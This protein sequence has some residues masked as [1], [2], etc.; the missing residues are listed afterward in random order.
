MVLEIFFLYL[1][2]LRSFV[3]RVDY[4]ASFADPTSFL[5]VVQPSDQSRSKEY[6][7]QHEVAKGHH[8][9]HQIWQSKQQLNLFFHFLKKKNRGAVFIFQVF[10][11]M[12]QVLLFLPGPQHELMIWRKAPWAFAL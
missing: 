9:L 10:Q 2:P 4:V 12:F 3:A 8:H 7:T 5:T 1:D 6:K 11:S